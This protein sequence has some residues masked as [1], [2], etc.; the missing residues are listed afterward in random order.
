[1]SDPLHQELKRRESHAAKVWW[2]FL[3]RP[4]QWLHWRRFEQIGGSCGWRSRIADARKLAR[5][6]GG[7][8]VWNRSIRRSAY[9]YVPAASEPSPER[10]T[11]PGA[12]YGAEPFEL[13]PPT[14]GVS[15]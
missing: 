7:Q 15:R 11:I 8:I 12:P 14:G 5:A 4:S 1:M 6:C 13:T 2:L 3:E 10:W 9:R